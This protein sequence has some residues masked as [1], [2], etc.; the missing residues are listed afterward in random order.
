M[1]N[2][3]TTSPL[4][5]TPVSSHR[6]RPLNWRERGVGIARIV[7]AGLGRCRSIAVAPPVSKLIRCSSCRGKGWS[8]RAHS[9]LDH[10]L[11]ERCQ[12]Q[13]VALCSYPGL[14]RGGDSS[15]LYSWP[16]LQPCGYRFHVSFSWDLGPP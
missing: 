7:F 15:L 13:S 2:N 12:C 5:Q 4:R 16:L 6:P 14:D 8:T 11:G 9:G 1:I 10:L 3:T